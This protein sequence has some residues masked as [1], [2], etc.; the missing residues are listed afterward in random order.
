MLDAQVALNRARNNFNSSLYDYNLAKTALD[1]AMGIEAR[2]DD[3]RYLT[4][5]ERYKATKAVYNAAVEATDSDKTLKETVKA[6]EKARSERR[7]TASAA[8]KKA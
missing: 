5:G 7:K 3:Y 6:L 8:K 1:T 4:Y 2:P